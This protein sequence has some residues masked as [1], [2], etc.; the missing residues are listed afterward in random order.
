M[1]EIW[2][3]REEALSWSGRESMNELHYQ[4]LLQHSPDIWE[5]QARFWYD[6]DIWFVE[7]KYTKEI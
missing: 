1:L 7:Q 4:I 3:G 6:K 5:E 2:K